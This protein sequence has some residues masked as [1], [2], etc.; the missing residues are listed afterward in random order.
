MN[1]VFT[2]S[3]GGAFQRADD[4]EAPETRLVRRAVNDR[5][6]ELDP[7]AYELETDVDGS[8]ESRLEDLGY[9]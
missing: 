3:G 8:L 6:A 1:A 2:T 4:A 7:S 5:L 9:L